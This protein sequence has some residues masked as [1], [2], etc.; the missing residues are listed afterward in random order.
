M[1]THKFCESPKVPVA[2]SNPADCENPA[3]H[4]TLEMFKL[5]KKRKK[6][7]KAAKESNNPYQDGCPATKGQ[8][9]DSS[10]QLIHTVAANYPDNP[11]PEEKKYTYMFFESLAM[12]YPCPHCAKDFQDSFARKPAEYVFLLHNNNSNP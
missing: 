4:S 12:V 7:I 11:S 9:G 5:A 1:A 6:F 3:C 8:L 2:S 10:W